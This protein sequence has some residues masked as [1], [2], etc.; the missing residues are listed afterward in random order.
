MKVRQLMVGIV[1]TAFASVAAADLD[2]WTDY[3]IASSISNVTTVKV[4]SNMVDKYLEGLRATWAPANEVAKELGHIESYGI[5]VSQLENSGDF[6][7]ILVIRMKSAA[8]LQPSKDRYDAF[9]KKWGEENQ[10]KSDEIVVT[11]PDIRT[12]TGEY[13]MREVTFK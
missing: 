5:Y 6:N 8:D 10:K 1:L 2:P 9:M 4:D 7:V 13:L 3:D 12:I 11:Y